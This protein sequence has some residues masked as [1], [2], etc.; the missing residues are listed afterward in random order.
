MVLVRKIELSTWTQVPEGFA[1]DK[2]PAELLSKCS[3]LKA[4]GNELSFWRFDAS[5]VAWR[6]E[7]TLAIVGGW[8]KLD[9]LHVAWMEEDALL[10]AGITLE[11]SAGETILAELKNNHVDAVRL[12][13][14]RL[15]TIARH[16]ALAIRSGSQFHTSTQQELAVQLA[17]AVEAKRVKLPNMPQ[18]LGEPVQ[19]ELARRTAAGR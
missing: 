1:A 9:G 13:L 11:P 16:L 19:V 7:A 10:A 6:G 4:I 15:A 3:D 18:K 14:S 5:D 12:D 17:D 2:V 8:K